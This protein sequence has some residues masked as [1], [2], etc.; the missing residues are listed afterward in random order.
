MPRVLITA[1]GTGGHIYPGLALAELLSSQGVQVSWLG[2]EIGMERQLVAERYD[3]H[4]IRVFQ[5]RGKGIK[6][7]L[8]FPLLL[9]RA[10]WQAYQLLR[11]LKPDYVVAFGGFAAGPGGVAA[12]LL[13]IPLIIH[14]QNARAGFT[15]RWLAKMATHITEAFPNSFG[16]KVKAI[17]V[18]NPVRDTILQLPEPQ[19]RLSQ[20]TGPLRI[21]ILGG[22]LGALAV[23]NAIVDWLSGYDRRAELVIKHQTGRAHIDRVKQSYVDQRCEGE[24][25]AYIEDM[26]AALAWADVVICRAGALTV[27]EIAAAGLAAIFIPMP[28]AVDNHQFHNANYLVL[29]GGGIMLEQVHLNSQNLSRH[30]SSL[31]DDRQRVL[32]MSEK[33]RAC[34]YTKATTEL[35]KL[36]CDFA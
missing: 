4:A 18:G 12:R 16:P 8:L 7:A 6:T 19:Q 15:N 5:L 21:L 23:N 25:V 32:Q 27:A 33:A 36:L 35:A 31:L 17:T 34:A 30:I 20:H 10:V 11:Q 26:P 13:G 24:V 9:T 3:F 22:S 2:S 29:K 1:G 28:H 14:E